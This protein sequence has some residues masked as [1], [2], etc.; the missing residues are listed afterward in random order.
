MKVFITVDYEGVAGMVTWDGADR[1]RERDFIT[2]DTNAA[3]EGAYQGGA[4]EVLVGEA[5]GN[6]RNLIPERLDPRVRFLSG[7]PKHLNHMHGIDGTFNAAM[8]IAYHA[9]SGTLGAVMAHTYS[10]EVSALR[11]NG[12]EVGELGADAALAGAHGVPVVLVTGDAAA[13]R[14]AAE[15]LGDVATVAVKEGI[16][17]SAA[18]CLPPEVARARIT[19]AAAAAVPRAKERPPFTFEAPVAVEVVFSDPSSADSACLIP[20]LERVDGR[21]VHFTGRDYVEA[22]RM[23]NAAHFLAGVVR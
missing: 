9:R 23:F 1:A 2:A 18:I 14:E 4:A 11:F 3:I 21:T 13:C 6:M 12:V 15:L 5:H 17:R 16:G 10:G 20:Q 7:Q 22:F 8:L 19:E